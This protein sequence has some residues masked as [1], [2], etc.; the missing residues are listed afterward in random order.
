[1]VFAGPFTLER[2][3]DGDGGR[4]TVFTNTATV[5]LNGTLKTFQQRTLDNY[6]TV[7]WT[8]GQLNIGF[9]ATWNN[10]GTLSIQGDHGT[11]AIGGTAPVFNNAGTLVKSSGAG[12]ANFGFVLNN[13][14]SV[15]S[16]SGT[17]SLVNGGLSTGAFTANGSCFLDFSGG[18]HTITNGASFAGAGLFRINGGGIFDVA[19]PLTVTPG[20]RTRRQRRARRREHDGL[21]RPLSPGAR[22]RWRRWAGAPSSPTP[23]RCA[24]PPSPSCP[25]SR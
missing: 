3:H 10:Y 25:R 23:P 5:T 2:G 6:T 12:S 7:N 14:S 11:G 1:M 4:R 20:L 15:L 24:R 16:Q 13:A 9:G 17:L 21:R 8:A 18:T 19:T 22:A